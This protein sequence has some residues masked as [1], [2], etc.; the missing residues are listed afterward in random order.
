MTYNCNIQYEDLLPIQLDSGKLLYEM[1]FHKV[2]LYHMDHTQ[3][4]DLGID[5]LC[6][7]GCQGSQDQLC[8]HHQRWEHIGCKDPL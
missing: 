4:K 6:K 7:L 8:I 2:L 5:V 3:Y 1:W